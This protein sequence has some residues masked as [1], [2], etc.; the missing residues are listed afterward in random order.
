ME[1]QE[2][3]KFQKVLNK[4]LEKRG[5]NANSLSK[6][7]GIPRSTIYSWLSGSYPDSRTI[8]SVKTLAD[9]FGVSLEYLL[10]EAKEKKEDTYLVNEIIS[11]R[12]G[13][14]Y[15]VKVSAIKKNYSEDANSSE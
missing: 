14:L 1:N 5:L 12:D 9:F 7:S 2:R 3:L 15:R 11:G 4:E 13:N 8:Y 10:F 6:K